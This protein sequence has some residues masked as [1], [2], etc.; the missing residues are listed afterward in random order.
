MSFFII[1]APYMAKHMWVAVRK[2]SALKKDELA[3]L[4]E[5]SYVLVRNKLPKKIQEQLRK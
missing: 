5:E 3:K 1:P 2:P 4:V